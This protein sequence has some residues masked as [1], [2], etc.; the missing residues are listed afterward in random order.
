LKVPLLLPQL[1]LFR[2]DLLFGFFPQLKGLIS[3]LDQPFLGFCFSLGQNPFGLV[4]GAFDQQFASILGV[5]IAHNR[6]HSQAHRPYDDGNDYWVHLSYVLSSFR[7][8]A[9][10]AASDGSGIIHPCSTRPNSD[11]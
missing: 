5:Q 3:G 7:P 10:M 11:L 9:S 6:A 2:F 4:Y 8:A 1:L